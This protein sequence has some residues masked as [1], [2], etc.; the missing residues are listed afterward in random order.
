[1][2]KSIFVLLSSILM[3]F[4]FITISNAS[5]D[6]SELDFR[7]LSDGTFVKFDS[8]IYSD[9]DTRVENSADFI[10]YGIT[11]HYGSGQLILSDAP[12][13]CYTAA[14][15]H[16]N[17]HTFVIYDIDSKFNYTFSEVVEPGGGVIGFDFRYRYLNHDV[18]DSSNVL[19][20]RKNVTEFSFPDMLN[21]D[22][23]LASGNFEYILI[24][25]RDY[26]NTKDFNFVIRKV[27]NLDNYESQ[28]VVF[29]ATLSSDSI[30]FKSVESGEVSEYYYEIPQ[31]DLGIEFNQGEKYLFTFEYNLFGGSYYDERAVIIRS[32]F[33]SRR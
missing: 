15:I 30:Y 14:Q 23:D 32:R 19:M 1:M 8:S 3:F 9:I 25:P 16:K 17:Y 5:T 21:T 4:S 26:S 20:Y 24:N 6:I 27:E 28:S 12:F 7:I 31:S 33:C 2:R 22:E 11:Y 18:Y 29:N 10:Y 13:V